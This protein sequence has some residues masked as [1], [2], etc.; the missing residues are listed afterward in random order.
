[1]NTSPDIELKPA[2]VF[3]TKGKG[4]VSRAIRF[5]TR[6]IG[7]SRTQVNHVGVVV[8]SGN[9]KTAVV[10]EALTRVKRHRLWNKYG[11]PK[12]DSVAIYRSKNLSQDEI[13]A[14]VAA[15]KSYVGRRY[16]YFKIFVHLVDW[17]LLGAYVFRRLARMDR[18]PICS[19]LVAHAFGKAGKHFGVEPGAAAPDD[20]WDFIQGHPQIY[21]EIYSLKPLA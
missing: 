15:A 19:W 16:G 12:K 3:L 9:L 13:E 17:I 20:I 1:M 5:F 6:G 2:D 7:E 21:E 10:V 8:E 18:Y 11:P 14:I 4:S